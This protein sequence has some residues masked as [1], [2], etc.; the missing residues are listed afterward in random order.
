MPRLSLY[1]GQWFLISAVIVSGAFLAISALFHGYYDIDSSVIGKYN[2]NYYFQNIKDQFNNIIQASD[3]TNMAANLKEF[4][5]FAE[6]SM[7][8]NGYVL[9]INYTIINCADKNVRRGFLL[10]SNKAVLYENVNPEDVISG[11]G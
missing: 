5:Y 7:Q 10:A 3:C 8:K 4:V 6:Q 1:K 9:F 11:Y 2:E